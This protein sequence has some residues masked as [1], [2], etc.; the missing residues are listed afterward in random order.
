MDVLWCA[1]GLTSVFVGCMAV[2]PQKGS[3]CGQMSLYYAGSDNHEGVIVMDT[4][5]VT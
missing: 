3:V 2:L 5:M 1:E 4:T